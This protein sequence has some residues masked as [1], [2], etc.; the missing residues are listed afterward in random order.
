MPPPG[1]G[2]L[3]GANSTSPETRSA[4]SSARFKASAPAQEWPTTMARSMP[5]SRSAARMMRAC[6]AGEGAPAPPM[7]S[8]QPLP[9]RST[10][11]TRKRC[12]SRSPS[13]IMGSPEEPEA[14]CRRSTVASG[15]RPCGAISTTCRRPPA[16]SMK[17]PAGG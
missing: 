15:S 14:P 12:A 3:T 13:A 10:A 17:R 1:Q 16:T 8:L 6:V 7:R 2:W 9:G 11:T 4:W 5:I